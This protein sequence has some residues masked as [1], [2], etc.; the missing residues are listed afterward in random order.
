MVNSHT[1]ISKYLMMVQ[2][3]TK[4]PDY[5]AVFSVAKIIG[6]TM[7]YKRSR[8]TLGDIHHIIVMW[9]NTHYL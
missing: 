7:V 2:H 4:I 5:T 1:I 9:A 6:M 3:V 8:K